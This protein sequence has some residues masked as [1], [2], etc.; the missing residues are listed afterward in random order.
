[1]LCFSVCVFAVVFLVASNTIFV[2]GLSF[3][4]EEADVKAFFDEF[5]EIRTVRIPVHQDTGRRK[6]MAFVEFVK[7]KHTH[8]Q[9]TRTRAVGARVEWSDWR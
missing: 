7:S 1:M 8:T 3:D 2:G 4:A 9:H 5:G 6:G